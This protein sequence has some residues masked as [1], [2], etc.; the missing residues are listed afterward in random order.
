MFL[1][2]FRRLDLKGIVLKSTKAT[3]HIKPVKLY[4]PELSSLPPAPHLRSLQYKGAKRGTIK[5]ILNHEPVKPGALVDSTHPVFDDKSFRPPAAGNEYFDAKV[6]PNVMLK[7]L[8]V[9]SMRNGKL[10][11]RPP[12]EPDL[13]VLKNKKRVKFAN[14]YYLIHPKPPV[15]HASWPDLIR[16][17]RDALS[18]VVQKGTEWTSSWKIQIAERE[19]AAL[20]RLAKREMRR[21]H[22]WRRQ[23][24]AA[25]ER[26]QIAEDVGI[27]WKKK[28]MGVRKRRIGNSRP[29]VR[30]GRAK[31]LRTPSREAFREGHV[32]AH[33]SPAK[34]APACSTERRGKGPELEGDS[35]R[36]GSRLPSAHSARLRNSRTPASQ[37]GTS[38]ARTGSQL[39]ARN[40]S[41]PIHSPKAEATSPSSK[42]AN[43]RSSSL[44]ESKVPKVAPQWGLVTKVKKRE[45]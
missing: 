18:K 17:T 31:S 41:E 1:H 10:Q 27:R 36:H 15:Y 40:P 30:I 34:S 3:N 11:P 38:R 44:Q 43:T 29:G 7:R 42:V 2:A 25:L 32:S 33:E 21:V 19:A 16:A 4:T 9:V 37:V 35:S 39:A 20:T 45:E 6:Y 28:G 22:M 26:G 8:G 23:D 5:P 12:K 13:P 14:W 24:Q